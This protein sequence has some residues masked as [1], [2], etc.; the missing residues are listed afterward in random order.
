[1]AIHKPVGEWY[2]YAPEWWLLDCTLSLGLALE[3]WKDGG[4]GLTEGLDGRS[5]VDGVCELVLWADVCGALFFFRFLTSTNRLHISFPSVSHTCSWPIRP[6]SPDLAIRPFSAFI[7]T[8]TLFAFR[9]ELILNRGAALDPL[10]FALDNS[11]GLSPPALVTYMRFSVLTFEMLFWWSALVAWM[12]FDGRKGGRSWRSQVR[13]PGNRLSTVLM[14]IV[15]QMTGIM[16]V[17]LQPS[18]ML[19]DNGHFQ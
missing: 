19:I 15:A 11:R 8:F 7:L 14:E 18:L 5:A 13:R 9:S 17:L 3:G 10:H 4:V 12:V 1:V 6:L 2:T 16:T